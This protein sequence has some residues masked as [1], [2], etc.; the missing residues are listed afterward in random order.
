[1]HIALRS[2]HGHLT[3]KKARKLLGIYEYSE[4][5]QTLSPPAKLGQNVKSRVHSL[6]LGTNVS[7][8]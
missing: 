5:S 4:I 2:I 1:M 3:A 8:S 7:F 6:C